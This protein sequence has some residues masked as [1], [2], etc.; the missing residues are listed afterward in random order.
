MTARRV[1]RAYRDSNDYFRLTLACGHDVTSSRDVFSYYKPGT[2]YMPPKK[3]RCY[4]CSALL[5]ELGKEARH[6]R[7]AIA[8]AKGA[9]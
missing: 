7:A 8:K 2:G 1:V 5:R 6:A 9:Q 4:H 3:V